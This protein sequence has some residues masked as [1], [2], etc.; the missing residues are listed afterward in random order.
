MLRYMLIKNI[1]SMLLRVA[2]RPLPGKYSKRSTETEGRSFPTLWSTT[3]LKQRKV[4]S[5]LTR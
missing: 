3:A 5:T 4:T 1:T 2:M